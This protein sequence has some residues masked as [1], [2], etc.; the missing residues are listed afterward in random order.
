M[1]ASLAALTLFVGGGL[2]LFTG[3]AFTVG[4]SK[5]ALAPR[6]VLI[7]NL[8][9]SFPESVQDPNPAGL[10]QRA[11]GGSEEPA[12]PL[13]GVL[14]ALDRAAKDKS[15]C[16]LYLTGNV[17]VQGYGSGPAALKEL[18][19]AIQRFK[20][21]SGKPVIAYNHLWDRREYYL[22]A[23]AS[24]VC[25]NP[26]GQLDMTGLSAE[27]MFFAGA[28]K[29]YGIQV[30]VTRVGRYKSAV[31]PYLLDRMSDASREQLSSLLGDIWEDWKD[32]VAESRR[33]APADIQDLS[34][35]W[36]IVQAQDALKAGLVDQ[37]ATPDQM[38]DE[39]KALAGR[40]ASD[41]DFPQVDMATYMHL[42]VPAQGHNRIALAFA[43][44]DIVD[45]NGRIGQVGGE[46]LSQELRKLRLDPQV[47]AVVLRVNSPGGSALA[48]ELIQREV[49]LTAKV[50][51]VVVSMGYLAASGGYW[52]ST[53]GTRIFAEPTTITGSIG[54]YGLLPNV[55]KLAND[56]GV[57]WDHLQTSRMAGLESIARPKTAAELARI[58]D[59]VNED[60][61]QFLARVSASRGMPRDKV[62]EIAQGRVWSGRQA[63]K[64]GLVDEL[65][66]IE[67]AV[68]YAAKR[69]HIEGDYR[70][71]NPAEPRTPLERILRML[72]DT[73]ERGFSQSGLGPASELRG[74]LEQLLANIQA[75]D[76][77]RGVYARMPFDLNLR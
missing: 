54:V 61:E 26:F 2:A 65:G 11:I 63:Q 57:T 19:E 45:G 59:L 12:L 15:I 70:V 18:R 74:R 75:L 21:E 4:S 40:K 3:I 37:L 7:L 39:L 1:L 31:E 44:G 50:K 27:P 17:R 8:S 56:H 32:A 5:P 24:K 73:E 16:A 52:I 72:N 71:D 6:S 20:T 69:A 30:Q 29:K 43:E 49:I 35:R 47:K 77:P 51:P 42:P 53:Y 10:I 28:L 76:D 48:S 13:A 41:P 66:G 38:L 14:Q 68:R 58:Q 62:D 22:C 34:D 64:L 60:Y 9:T 46:R 23:G 67:D 36:G 25:V 33:L 55:Q